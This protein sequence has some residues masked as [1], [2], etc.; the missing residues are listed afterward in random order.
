MN[1]TRATATRGYVLGSG[2]G[3]GRPGGAA[4]TTRAS[5]QNLH[6]T[7]TVISSNYFITQGGIR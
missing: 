2:E 5:D 3:D 4:V 1:K 6:D 7:A